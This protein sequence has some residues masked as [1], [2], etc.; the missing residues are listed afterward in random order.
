MKYK[1]TFIFTLRR[2]SVQFLD[3]CRPRPL[4]LVLSS[5]LARCLPRVLP[6]VLPCVLS[7][8]LALALPLISA[9]P[10][11][12]FHCNVIGDKY[13]DDSRVVTESKEN[14]PSST[15]KPRCSAAMFAN[16]CQSSFFTCRY[17]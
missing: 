2:G 4:S 13:D 17:L 10:A 9:L 14:S 7:G 15:S 3:D 6:R 1:Q 11:A 5:V 8:A 12:V 16:S